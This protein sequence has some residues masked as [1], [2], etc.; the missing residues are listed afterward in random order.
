MIRFYFMMSGFALLLSGCLGVASAEE[1]CI[2]GRTSTGKACGKKKVKKVKKGRDPKKPSTGTEGGECYGNNTCNA[3]LACDAGRCKRDTAPGG[4]SAGKVR[5]RYTKGNCCWRGQAWWAGKCVGKPTVCPDGT[6][7]TSSGC[8]APTCEA[9]KERV[10]DGIHCCYPGQAWV[11]SPN[12]CVGK[13]SSCP[14]DLVASGESCACPAGKALTSMT[15]AS[16]E[17]VSVPDGMVLVPAGSFRMGR[18]SGNGDEKP[19][20]EVY[21]SGFFIDTY[22]VTAS[23]YEA[24]VRAGGC[25]APK[26]THEYSSYYNYGAS[27][28]GKHP[29]N[30]VTWDQAVAYCEWA[31]KRLPTE[32]EW[33]KA[34]RGT[35]GRKYPWGNE[36]AT[37]RYAVMV[38]VDGEDDRNDGCGKQRTWEVGSKPAGVSPYG[39]H[40]MAGNVSEW[41]SDW[42]DREY[43]AYSPERDP[44][45]PVL[46]TGRVARGGSLFNYGDSLRGEVRDSNKPSFTYHRIGFRCVRSLN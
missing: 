28:R 35:D 16:C 18:E 37:C 14:G 26:Y 12:M 5:S 38:D 15:E 40:D 9:G 44:K 29:I 43:Y 13:P 27:E 23:Q 11:N 39:A 22:E 45:G 30:G 20:H 46:G 6:Y 10:S 21:V 34:A 1:P 32:A 41:V 42:Y 3:G 33:E 31:N 25:T 7:R 2:D 24:C 36:W 4:C 19:V 17:R 8:E